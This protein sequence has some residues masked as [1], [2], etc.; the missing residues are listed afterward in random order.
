MDNTT[1]QFI[2]HQSALAWF[3]IRVFQA[4]KLITLVGIVII[5][6]MKG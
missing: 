1:V 5:V 2:A 3:N 6:A 4:S